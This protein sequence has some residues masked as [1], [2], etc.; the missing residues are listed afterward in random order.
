M[1][2]TGRGYEETEMTDDIETTPGLDKLITMESG[3]AEAAA[4]HDF[5][6][7]AVPFSPPVEAFSPGSAIRETFALWWTAEMSTPEAA[8]RP[9]EVGSMIRVGGRHTDPYD[10]K[11]LFK[12]LRRKHRVRP[13]GPRLLWPDDKSEEPPVMKVNVRITYPLHQP[14]ERDFDIKLSRIGDVFGFAYDLYREVYDTE[15]AMREKGTPAPRVGERGG[16]PKCM[17]R[18][19]GPLVWGHDMGDLIFESLHF[20]PSDKEGHL[21]FVEFGIGS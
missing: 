18:A 3:A 12:I 20:A 17:N 4:Q 5:E 15:D 2:A 10:L 13:E 14:K 11:E 16:H 9:V 21:G 7:H 8:A 19:S 1:G 6:S